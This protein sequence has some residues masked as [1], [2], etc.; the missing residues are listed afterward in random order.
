MGGL[1]NVS[2][3]LPYGGLTNHLMGG[4]HNG[5]TYIPYGGLTYLMG[6]YLPNGGM[7]YLMG[8]YLMGLPTFLMGDLPT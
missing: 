7:A 2:I 8:A 4:L 3:Y 6:V 5:S 1:P